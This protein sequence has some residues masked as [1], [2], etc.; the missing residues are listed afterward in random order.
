MISRPTGVLDRVRESVGVQRTEACLCKAHWCEL[1]LHCVHDPG[2]VRVV[3][4]ICQQLLH[5]RL[6]GCRIQ[7]PCVLEP[8]K[9][10]RRTRKERWQ[11]DS[12]QVRDGAI[13]QVKLRCHSNDVFGF[14]GGVAADGGEAGCSWHWQA[15]KMR[16]PRKSFGEWGCG[17]STFVDTPECMGSTKACENASSISVDCFH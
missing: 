2:G 16:C 1:A 13:R 7:L 8:E 3:V 10:F 14:S 11:G 17:E 9:L 12:D 5:I 6:A 15:L 4:E